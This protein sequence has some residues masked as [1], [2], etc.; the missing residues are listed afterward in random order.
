MPNIQKLAIITQ[1]TVTAADAASLDTAVNAAVIA[2]ADNTIGLTDVTGAPSGNQTVI[3]N[4]IVI[5][6]GTP[7]INKAGNDLYSATITFNAITQ[8][9]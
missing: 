1:Q 4:S 5:I 8:L 9:V 6:P 7:F 3:P 2:I